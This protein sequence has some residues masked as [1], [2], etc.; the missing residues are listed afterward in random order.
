MGLCQSSQIVQDTEVLQ[1][2]VAHYGAEGLRGAWHWSFLLMRDGNSGDSTAYQI[3]GSEQTYAYE[4]PDRQVDVAR[5]RSF[6]GKVHVGSIPAD[7]LHD[8]EQALNDVPVIRGTRTGWNCQNWIMDALARLHAA[9]FPVEVINHTE[10]LQELE[11]AKRELALE[12][13]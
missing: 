13:A 10:L 3:R 9:R 1:L 5:S 11:T 12:G 7:R 4:G 6:Q 8:F 2:Y